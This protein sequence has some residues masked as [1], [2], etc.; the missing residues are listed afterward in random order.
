M[1]NDSDDSDFIPNQNKID[2]DDSPTSSG[3]GAD[4]ITIITW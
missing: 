2:V 1:M 3:S 4:L